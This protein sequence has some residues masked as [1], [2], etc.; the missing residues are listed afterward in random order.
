M[1]RYLHLQTGLVVGSGL[2]FETIPVVFDV[3][4]L[5]LRIGQCSDQNKTSESFGISTHNFAY[6]RKERNA[7][8]K[9]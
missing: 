3:F 7:F 9:L 8:E 4:V 6:N 1:L 5:G 2:L